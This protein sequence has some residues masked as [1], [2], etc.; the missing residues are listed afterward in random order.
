MRNYNRAYR[1][2]FVCD[3]CHEENQ[4][5]M[6]D[7]FVSMVVV[8]GLLMATS[9]SEKKK[10]DDIIAPKP[11]IV[12]AKD[13]VKMQGYEHSESVEWLGKDYTVVI[14]RSVDESAP[15]FADESDNKY[16]ENRVVLTVLRPDGTQFFNRELTKHSFDSYVDAAYMQHST[17]LGIAVLKTGDDAIELLASVGCPDELSDDYVPISVIL[18]RTGNITMKK[19]GTLGVSNN[20][21]DEG[22]EGV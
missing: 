19:S 15:V 13:P 18:S 5:G 21:N 4:T 7:I 10:S 16:Y 3:G 9:C 22:D 20:P 17:I 2:P 1:R 12:K 6:K 11:I 14:K 8:A